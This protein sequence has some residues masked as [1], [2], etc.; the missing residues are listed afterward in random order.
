MEKITVDISSENVVLS[1]SEVGIPGPRGI[2]GPKG[3][4]LT[5]DDLTIAQK[6]A[7]KG[8]KLAYADLTPGDKFDLSQVAIEAT[9]PFVKQA[10]NAVV[11]AQN[12]ATKA[13]AS[14]TDAAASALKA[15]AAQTTSKPTPHT[16]PFNEITEV[17]ETATRWPT[18]DEVK[19]K[20]VEYP[21]G[22]HMQPWSTITDIP[23]QITRF[24]T[25][26]EVGALPKTYKPDWDSIGNKPE[27]ATR[28]PTVQE[29][30]IRPADIGALGAAN[31]AKDSER[32]E[33][34]LPSSDNSP[35]TIPVRDEFGMCGFRSITLNYQSQSELPDGGSVAFRVNNVDDTMLRFV[36][37]DGLVEWLGQVNDSYR[38]AGRT[39]D[40]VITSARVGLVADTATVNGKSLSGPVEITAADVGVGNV[41]NYGNT[42]SC[43]GQSTTLYA[44][45]K[46]AYDAS[47]APALSDERKR[48]VFYTNKP[49][50]PEEGD[51]FIRL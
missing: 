3:K 7:L 44:T 40:Q 50:A 15:L 24:P 33:G 38:F 2:Q 21:P 11:D 16:H 43:G 48:R 28:W 6:N 5:W 51:I 4:P 42:S 20:P 26:D 47:F 8:D 49:L 10:E 34:M 31:K 22:S 12:E 45:Q 29:L 39:I 1:L 14:A 19:N 35:S 17:P 41:A 25:A 37:R 18:F 9:K 46:A 32:L 13:A 36:S 23:E 27:T 30:N